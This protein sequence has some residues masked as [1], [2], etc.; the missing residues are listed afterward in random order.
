MITIFKQRQ[1]KGCQGWRLRGVTAN[2][3]QEYGCATGHGSG[4]W[5]WES[6]DKLGQSGVSANRCDDAHGDK[7]YSLLSPQ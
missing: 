7:E 4:W 5:D 2:R 3:G 6:L 1:I